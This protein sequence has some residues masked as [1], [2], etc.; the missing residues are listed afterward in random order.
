MLAP[1]IS[2]L[3]LFQKIP[4]ADKDI[5][6]AKGF[7]CRTVKEGE[8]LLRA[9]KKAKEM[10]FVCKGVLKI[11]GTSD[12]GNEVV[13]YFFSE[14]HFCTVMKSFTENIPSEDSIVA[15]CEA[16]VIVLPKDKLQS[17]FNELP[18]IKNLF[19]KIIR[20]ALLNKIELRNAYLGEDA[21]ARYQKFIVRQSNIALRVS[22]ADIASYFGVTKQSLSRIRRN[23]H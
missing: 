3:E 20:Q 11:T 15:A 10:F 14:N 6:R 16:E 2:Y 21:T 18:G 8:V 13:H 1:L 22:Q 23:I 4:T 7:L 19:D 12:K 5:I 17:L 9:G